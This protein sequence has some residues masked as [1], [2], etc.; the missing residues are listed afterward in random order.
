MFSFFK[1]LV[2][3]LVAL[4][5]VRAVPFMQVSCSV[6]SGTSVGFSHAFDFPNEDAVYHIVNVATDTNLYAGPMNGP[7]NMAV[8]HQAPQGKAAEWVFIRRL[9]RGGFEVLNRDLRTPVFTSEEKLYDGYLHPAEIVAVESAG[10][11]QFILTFSFKIKE[12]NRDAVWTVE[13]DREVRLAPSKGLREQRWRL[14]E[15]PQ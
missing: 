2:L 4:S 6:D 8:K 1:V 11:G 3:G 10:D 9:S 14:I 15:V 7:L 12:V 5:S 13:N